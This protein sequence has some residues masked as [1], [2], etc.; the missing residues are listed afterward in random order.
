MKIYFKNFIYSDFSDYIISKHLFTT[1]ILTYYHYSLPQIIHLVKMFTPNVT[2]N[3]INNV[4]M[5]VIITQKWVSCKISVG[6][7]LGFDVPNNKTNTANK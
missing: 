1:V 2:L 7:Y 4:R 3:L 5:R 6:I